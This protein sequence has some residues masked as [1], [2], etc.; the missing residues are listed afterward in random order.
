MSIISTTYIHT[1]IKTDTTIFKTFRIWIQISEEN[2]L[3]YIHICKIHFII[4]N[5]P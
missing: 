1:Y 2:I 5:Y 3:N 4:N